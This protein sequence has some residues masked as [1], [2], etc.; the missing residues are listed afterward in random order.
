MKALRDETAER[1]AKKKQYL[2][3]EDLE[4]LLHQYHKGSFYMITGGG[5]NN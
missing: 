1:I 2:D 3:E 5:N 4:A